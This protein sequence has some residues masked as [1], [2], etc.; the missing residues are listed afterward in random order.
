MNNKFLDYLLAAEFEA[1]G[2]VNAKMTFSCHAISKMD[3]PFPLMVLL[4]AR[5]QNAQIFLQHH[6]HF[7]Y[8]VHDQQFLSSCSL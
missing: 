7:T 4:V 5:M 6:Q 8:P 1:G 3:K 2:A